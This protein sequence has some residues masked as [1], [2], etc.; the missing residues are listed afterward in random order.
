MKPARK[1]DHL[2]KELIWRDDPDGLYPFKLFWM[3]GKKDMEGFNGC[4]SYGFVKE[5]GMMHPMDGGMVVHPYNEVLAFC[6]INTTTSWTWGPRSP[7]RSGK[8]GRC[9]P[10]TRPMWS[11]FPPARPTAG[12]R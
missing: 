11:V 1:Y 7:S 12:S 8:N 4:F 9:I 2:V 5:E 3:E 6:S 10:L